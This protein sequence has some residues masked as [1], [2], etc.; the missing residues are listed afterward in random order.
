MKKNITASD[1]RT[2]S[3]LTAVVLAIPGFWK[4]F[5]GIHVWLSPFLMLNSVFA[6][7]SFVLLNIIALPVLVLI[8]I[9]K[10]WFCK[11]LCPAGWCFDKVSALSRSDKYDYGKVPE[12]GKWLAIT[13]LVAALFGFPL[14]VIL[15]PLSIFNWFFCD[16]LREAGYCCYSFF[17]AFSSPF[18]DPLILSGDMVQEIVSSRRSPDKFVGYQNIF[19]AAICAEKT[20]TCAGITRKAIFYHVGSRAACRIDNPPVN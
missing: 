13:S 11:Y 6:L 9:R 12:I 14:F 1:I 17:Y 18:A 16:L 19:V 3:F 2:I 8:I 10:R 20:C 5:Q 4:G 15:D 7:K